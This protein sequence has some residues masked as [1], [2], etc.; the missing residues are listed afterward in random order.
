MASDSGLFRDKIAVVTGGGSGLGRALCLELARR[1]AVTVVT[2]ID[3]KSAAQVTESITAAGGRSRAMKV[4]VADPGSVTESID[5]VIRAYGGLDYLFN[6]A[7]IIT[8][9]EVRDMRLE[10]WKRIIDVNL[11]GV[12][13]GIIPAYSQMV[14]QGRGHI[15]NVASVGGLITLPTYTAYATTKHAVV[16]LSNSLRLEGF[17]LGVKVSVACPGMMN[18]G[19]G[20]SATILHAKRENIHESP[21]NK[22]AMDPAAAARLVLR[23]VERNKG[24]IVFPFSSG[25]L[26]RLYRMWPNL[27]APMGSR[28]LSTFR[29]VRTNTP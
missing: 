29:A 3:L 20:G 7:G 13:Y 18:T 25:L 14:K 23:G 6:N 27:L 28:M 17:A 22:Y 4:D 8:L 2:D 11:L 26:W 5:E 15:V 9:A 1:G 19:L 10:H 24:M 16:A 21:M 12:V